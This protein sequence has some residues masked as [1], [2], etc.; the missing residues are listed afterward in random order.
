MYHTTGFAKDDVVEL[1]AML[2]R[3]SVEEG[4]RFWPPRLG[5]FRSVVVALTYARRNRVQVEI[6]EAF[7]VSQ[8]TV[9]RAVTGVT[10]RL[11]QVLADLVPT[12]EDLDPDAA[13]VVD[14][15]LLPCWSWRSR[16]GLFSGKHRTTGMNVQ[17]AC[18]LS[19]RLAWIGDA[20]EGSRHDTYCLRESGVL[21][22][23]DPTTW[24]GDKGYVGNDMTTPVKKPR[25]RDL[26]DTDT[27]FNKQVNK[28]RYVI[29]QVISHLKN[30]TILHT[31]YRRPIHTF[32][33]TISTVIALHFY[34]T[35]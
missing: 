19:G 27:D 13:Y 33:E 6:G 22:T 14:G 5:L 12:A 25:H 8:P 31:D 15:T 20:V 7:G 9:S 16:P 29:E 4:I 32:K 3:V 23:L 24:V 21:T 35:A 18:T 26:T 2:Y 11:G 17:V 34:Q 30:W 1:C 28:I 10:P